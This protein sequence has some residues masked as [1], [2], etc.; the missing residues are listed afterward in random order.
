MSEPLP[1]IILPESSASPVFCFCDHAT[2]HIPVQYEQLGLSERD[3]ARHIAWDIGAETLTRQFCTT[4]G[5][6]GLLAGFS[7]LVIDAN[8]DTAS[9]GLIPEVSDGTSVPANQNLSQDMR[10]ERIDQFYEP[11]H[12]ALEQQLDAAQARSK[13]PLIVSIHSFTPKPQNGTHREIDIGLLWK[14]D[15]ALADDV[16]AE[17]EKVH[18]Y[19]VAL[20]EPYSALKLNHSMDRHVIPR[21]LRHITF[22]VR[23]DLIDTEANALVMAQRLSE[24]LRHFI[25][26]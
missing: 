25:K 1:Y 14:V 16:K 22:E 9:A 19:K 20:N 11:Y 6:A 7:R 23:Q 17:I 4:F 5:A 13:D 2:N 15:E 26:M 10:A 18:P 12:L 21:G 8:R 3:L 24:A